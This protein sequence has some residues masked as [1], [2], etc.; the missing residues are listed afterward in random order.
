MSGV[1]RQAWHR[2]LHGT[3]IPAVPVP[4]RSDGSIDWAAQEAYIDYMRSQPA[5]GVA[6]WSHSGR[7]LDLSRQ[8]RLAVMQA[9]RTGLPS[10]RFIVGA[11]GV[12]HEPGS[13]ALSERAVFDAAVAMAADAIESGAEVLLVHPPTMFRGR[14][15]QDRAVIEYHERLAR[16]DVPLIV[17]YLHEAAGGIPYSP[18]VLAE[19]MQLDQVVGIKMAT[20]DSVVTFQDVA[21][22]LQARFGQVTLIS[23]E[24]RFLGYSIMRGATAALVGLAAACTAMQHELLRAYLDGRGEAFLVCSGRVDAFAEVTFIEPIEGYIRRMLLALSVLNV[25]PTSAC[26]DPWGPPVPEH[27]RDAIAEVL[28]RIG[29]LA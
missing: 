18:D 26:Y 3:L 29:Q 19:L 23:G 16:P 28:R 27:E 9:W 12:A 4:H 13:G 21:R 20:L 22:L 10:E 6:V 14:D 24:D 11:A 8:D 25:I 15:D 2:R 5:G 7:G 17:F 1:D